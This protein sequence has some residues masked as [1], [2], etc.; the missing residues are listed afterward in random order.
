MSQLGPGMASQLIP[1]L[2]RSHSESSLLPNGL[3]PWPF[4]LHTLKSEC[5]AG[6]LVGRGPIA[7]SKLVAFSP[8]RSSMGSVPGGSVV[9]A[10]AVVDVAVAASS[11]MVGI[12]TVDVSLG[13]GVPVPVCKLPRKLPAATEMP[14]SNRRRCI[15]P[16]NRSFQQERC[17]FLL[18]GLVQ[19]G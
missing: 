11:V 16:S 10:A 6:Q 17:D 4:A 12:A 1:Q 7:L 3:M 8:N 13:D 14:T 2:Q 19:S 15:M 9:V 18:D 5:S